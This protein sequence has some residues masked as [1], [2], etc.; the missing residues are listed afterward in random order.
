MSTARPETAAAPRAR[1]RNPFARRDSAD[2]GPRARF[3]ELLPYI[4]EQRGLMAF[5]VVLSVLGA[6]ASLG[7]PLLVQRVVGVVQEAGQLGVLVWALVGLVVVSGVLSG[8]Q[9]YL[10]QRMGEGIVLSSRRTLVRRI[11]RLPISEFDT[12]RT[13]DLV[14]RVGSDTTLLRAVLTQGLVEAIGGA[15]TFLGAII[16]M[17]I[18]DPVLLSLTVLVVAVSVVAVVGLSGRIRVAS[19]RAQRKVGDLAASVERAIGAIRTVRASNA[20]DREIRAIETDAEG[21][22]EMGIKVA[23]ASAVVVPIAGIA[24]QASFLVVVGVGGYRVAAGAITV[25]DLVAFILFLFL[26]IMPLGQAFGA[27]TA[28]NQALGALGR[29]QEIVKLPVETDGDADLAGRLRDGLPAADDRTDAPAVEL[30]DVRF[31]YPVAAE[32]DGAADADAAASEGSASP[33]DGDDAPGA[34]RTGGG[35]LQGI[36][37]RAERGTRIALVG[38]SGAGKSTILALIERFYDPTSGVVRV[39]GRDIRTLDRED[40][41]RQIGYVE[42]DAPVLAGT[43]REN[44]TLTAFDATDEDCIQVLHAVNLT[45]VLARN[46][47]GLDAP[48]GEDGIMLSGGERQRLAIARTLLSAPPILLLD[49]STSSLDG[50]NEQLLR[51]AIDAV[52]EHRT[53]I[54]IAHRLSTVV[55]SD[56]IVVVEKGRVVGTGTHA[57]LVVSTPLYRDLA[58]HQLLV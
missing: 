57:E 11:L 56:L 32:A 26:M 48:V 24:L 15:V 47:L 54:V 40:L 55:D 9:H 2:D 8:Y 30:V 10:L 16:A 49:E 20:T 45:E 28:V 31:A 22:W 1:S 13:G 46:E 58:K 5:V 41:R 36:S 29:I 3:S 17:L 4:L 37:F 6:A 51:K 52:A 7:Q 38:P 23:K 34:D 19:Q 12:R 44:L 50:L 25:G 21:A 18:I 27:V 33:G 53:L 42:Q 14:S 43:L 35:V 39:G